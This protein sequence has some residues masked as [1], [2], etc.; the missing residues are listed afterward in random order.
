MCKD[1]EAC[2]CCIP[3]KAGT[4]TIL[5]LNL[6]AYLGGFAD[7]TNTYY[8]IWGVLGALVTV[9]ALIGVV[10]N[11]RTLLMIYFWWC[12]VAI[13][14]F[15]GVAIA[16]IVLVGVVCGEVYD[17]AHSD[18]NGVKD[19]TWNQADK[20]SLAG[21]CALFPSI[22]WGILAAI[23]LPLEIHFMCVVRSYAHSLAPDTVSTWL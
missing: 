17:A 15:I 16:S 1:M 3:L 13:F 8:L 21:T 4:I 6:L 5:I 9:L 2:C 14:L 12:L 22:I 10:Q 18:F 19:N 7:T 11:N 23:Y 20:T